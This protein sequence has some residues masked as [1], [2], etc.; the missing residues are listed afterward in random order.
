MTGGIPST[1]WFIIFAAIAAL[2]VLATGCSSAPAGLSPAAKRFEARQTAFDRA[3]PGLVICEAAVVVLVSE[4]YEGM[5]NGGYAITPADAVLK[6]P[7]SVAVQVYPHFYEALLSYVASHGLKGN[8]AVLAVAGGKVNTLLRKR[9][10]AALAA[11]QH[12]VA[13]ASP[14]ATQPGYASALAVWKQTPAAAAASAS[15]NFLRAADDLRTGGADYASAITELTSLAS[16]P[17]TGATS[18]QQTTAQA[19]VT[20]L[21]S[22]FGTPGLT[23]NG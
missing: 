6:Y 8:G 22:F 15:L 20:A 2:T 10:L 11:D 7:G 9:C 18:R 1:R 19:D 21:N 23:P 5:Q 3:H 17:E 4:S 13:P 12:R 16:I 14:A